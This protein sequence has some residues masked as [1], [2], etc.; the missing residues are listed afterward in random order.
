MTRHRFGMACAIAITLAYLA[1][2]LAIPFGLVPDNHR[3]EL[4]EVA[5][6]VVL[7]AGVAFAA[8]PYS[9][10][11]LTIGAGGVS[12]RL[13]RYEAKQRHLE[14]D[15]RALQV[16]LTGVVTKY[17]WDHLRNLARG[18]PVP[19]R[20]RHDRKLQLE[21]ERL[22]AMGFVEPV[23]PRGLNAIPEDH[24]AHDGEFDLAHYVR[25]TAE[26]REYLALRDAL[27]PGA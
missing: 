4:H 3:L 12:A 17:E 11:D 23:D 9:I 22:D 15:L 26:G 14:S 10:T 6:A 8:G 24:G 20:F 27:K 5:L 21:L 1:Y 25:V 18:G 19:A 7:L 13:A 2:L 16:A